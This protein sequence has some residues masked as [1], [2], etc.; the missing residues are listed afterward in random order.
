MTRQIIL[1]SHER[2]AKGMHH[3]LDF[4]AGQQS[5]VYDLSAY[6]DNQPIETTIEAMVKQFAA[7]DELIIFTDMLQG[8]V[9]QKFFPYRS[10]PHTHL[11]SGMNLPAVLALTL[12]PSADYLSGQRVREILEEAR[13]QIVYVNDIQTE[14]DED[15]E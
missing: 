8:S 7:E 12:E 13:Q 10:R 4:I 15:D 9:N 6:V 3:T 2:L 14:A 5:T 11:I 1:A